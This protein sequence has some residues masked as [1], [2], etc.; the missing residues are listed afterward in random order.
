MVTVNLQ[1]NPDPNSDKQK[2]V[3]ATL[4]DKN[5]VDAALQRQAEAYAQEQK[6]QKQA[7]EQLLAQERRAEQLKVEAEEAKLAVATANAQKLKI[8]ADA[9]KAAESKLQLEQEQQ[10]LKKQLAQAKKTQEKK[11][12]ATKQANQKKEQVAKQAADK[13]AA[14]QRAQ[15]VAKT[16][17]LKAQ[18]AAR[19]A[20]IKAQQDRVAAEHQEFL[21]SEVDKYRAAFQA[22]V[23]DN[24]ILSGV[25]S[26]EIICR[27]RIQLLPDGS[28]AS[29]SVVESSG[30]PAYDKMSS[31]AVYKSAP[32]PMPSDQELYGQLRDVVLSFR[33][34]DQSS[35]AI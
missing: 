10:Q 23:E 27:I 19:A 32:F 16:N 3:K 33:N 7:E 8:E 13:K 29:A 15:E 11:D 12:L 2:I 9:K 14:E 25:F 17:A 1:M 28:I 4:I 5:S 21:L 34:G 24:R 30:N 18:Q 22:V 26:G 31:D 35:D 20:G 6:K